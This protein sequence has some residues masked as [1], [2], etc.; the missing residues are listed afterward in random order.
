M[1]DKAAN[2]SEIHTSKRLGQATTNGL[3]M[4][5]AAFVRALG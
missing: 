1:A 3:T 2:A 4:T 5:I